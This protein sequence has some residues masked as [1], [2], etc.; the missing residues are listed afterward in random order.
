MG[1]SAMR[2]Q[3]P[4]PAQSSNSL[5]PESSS[6]LTGAR[7]AVTLTQLD[8]LCHH[9]ATK[10]EQAE[11]HESKLQ[12]QIADASE[13]ARSAQEA[14]DKLA[15]GMRA[16]ER[17]ASTA[18][19]GFDLL[20]EGTIDFASA[21]LAPGMAYPYSLKGKRIPPLREEQTPL[22]FAARGTSNSRDLPW[23]ASHEDLS[24]RQLW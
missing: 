12:E 11:Q 16:G 8:E 10:F 1:V 19:P 13:Q 21:A 22:R 2:S 15:A 24:G 18:K 3:A 9:L 17:C 23:K 14:V 20:P 5:E 7:L 6:P 4:V